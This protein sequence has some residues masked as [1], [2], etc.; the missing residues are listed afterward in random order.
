VNV[1][2]QEI[3]EKLGF[4]NSGYMLKLYKKK[5]GTTLKSDSKII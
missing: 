2:L 4:Y 3:A 5:M 1:S